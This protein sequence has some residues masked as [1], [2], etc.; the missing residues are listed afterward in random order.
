MQPEL[1]QVCHVQARLGSPGPCPLPHFCLRI[2]WMAEVLLFLQVSP[3]NMRCLY[4]VHRHAVRVCVHRG[5]AAQASP[6]SAA[7][8]SSGATL[9]ITPTDLLQPGLVPAMSCGEAE[10]HYSRW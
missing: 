10:P 6:P 1:L 7:C 9:L 2:L 5:E 3:A 4:S 8:L